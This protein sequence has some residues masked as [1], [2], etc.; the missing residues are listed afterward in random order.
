MKKE[1][2]IFVIL[3]L[4]VSLGILI[5]EDK[6]NL[7]Q[8]EEYSSIKEINIDV[9]ITDIIVKRT[10]SNKVEVY[11]YGNKKDEYKL[12]QTENIVNINKKFHKSFCLVS[13]FNKII[14]FIPDNFE[15]INIKHEQGDIKIDPIVKVVNIEGKMTDIEINESNVLNIKVINGDIDINKFVSLG[16][17]SIENERGDIDIDHLSNTSVTIGSKRKYPEKE[18]NLLLKSKFGEIDYDI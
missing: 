10:F 12:E 8:K 14:I 6:T 9:D 16:D 15:K 2:I 13:C 7:L 3:V 5:I 4:S 18:Y 11:L 1:I 17:S